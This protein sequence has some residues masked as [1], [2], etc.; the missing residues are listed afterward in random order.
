MDLWILRQRFLFCRARLSFKKKEESLGNH[1]H[2]ESQKSIK[3]RVTSAYRV[4]HTNVHAQVLIAMICNAITGQLSAQEK[5]IGQVTKEAES[6]FI[7]DPEAIG[8]REL[9]Q[10]TRTLDE[11]V[12]THERDDSSRHEFPFANE[13]QQTHPSL[14]SGD[15]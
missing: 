6:F 15:P 9:H 13:I 2:D 10:H 14:K 8:T 7:K 12:Q 11:N 1:D 4:V 5:E 3:E